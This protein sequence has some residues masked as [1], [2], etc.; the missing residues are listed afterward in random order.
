MP[1]HGQRGSARGQTEVNIWR[2]KGLVSNWRWQCLKDTHVFDMRAQRTRVLPTREGRQK[3]Q[4]A[5]S[6]ETGKIIRYS[7]EMPTTVI[8]V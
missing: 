3:K 4:Q 5:R 1:L 7:T 2:G 8:W 6:E